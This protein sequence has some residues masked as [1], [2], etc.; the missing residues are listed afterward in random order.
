MEGILRDQK[1]L[2]P[3]KQQHQKHTYQNKRAGNDFGPSEAPPTDLERAER[4]LDFLSR[5]AEGDR[6]VLRVLRNIG[7]VNTTMPSVNERRIHAQEAL[8][9]WQFAQKQSVT[10]IRQDPPTSVLKSVNEQW[11]E[12]L[13]DAERATGGV[14]FAAIG[15]DAFYRR[16]LWLDTLSDPVA[17]LRSKSQQQR[18][19]PQLP[20]AKGIQRKKGLVSG[21]TQDLRHG[22]ASSDKDGAGADDNGFLSHRR[23]S[24]TALRSDF[25]KFV[26]NST[27]TI[28]VYPITDA[29]L[30][31]YIHRR[32]HRLGYQH[33]TFSKGKMEHISRAVGIE[34]NE[35][36]LPDDQKQKLKPKSI[37][38]EE[39]QVTLP[40]EK[41]S[42]R[43][44]RRTDPYFPRTII[45]RKKLQSETTSTETAELRT[46]TNK[47]GGTTAKHTHKGKWKRNVRRVEKDPEALCA[48]EHMVKRLQRGYYPI[49]IPLYSQALPDFSSTLDHQ[50]E[51][52]REHVSGEEGKPY[53][54]WNRQ[55]RGRVENQGHECDFGKEGVRTQEEARGKMHDGSRNG[56]TGNSCLPC[57]G[58]PRLSTR[59]GTENSVDV[60]RAHRELEDDV[61][62]DA[63]IRYDLHGLRRADLHDTRLAVTLFGLWPGG[64][65]LDRFRK[66]SEWRMLLRHVIPRGVVGGGPYQRTRGIGRKTGSKGGKVNKRHRPTRGGGGRR[67]GRGGGGA[68]WERIRD[69]TFLLRELESIK[70]LWSYLPEGWY[71]TTAR[72]PS[73]FFLHLS[74]P[75]HN[76]ERASK[77]HESLHWSSRIGIDDEVIV[78]GGRVEGDEEETKKDEDLAL[79]ARREREFLWRLEQRALL[80]GNMGEN[81]KEG[82]SERNRGNRG[83]VS[84]ML[85]GSTMENVE[86]K[87]TI[88]TNVSQ[89]EH[90]GWRW[91]RVVGEKGRSYGS[92]MRAQGYKIGMDGVPYPPAS[93]FSPWS[94]T[95]SSRRPFNSSYMWAGPRRARWRR[96]WINDLFLNSFR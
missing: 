52:V 33:E 45:V 40:A 93:L 11:M 25:D 7:T 30:R 94:Y 58:D 71:E 20:Q 66:Q 34:A 16:S 3:G 81:K 37:E 80:H 48:V 44:A 85:S 72:D 62:P 55:S 60:H 28:A 18:R 90:A 13:Q 29:K 86:R 43:V 56:S 73:P 69:G 67:G 5:A 65:M 42:S 70:D 38:Q 54:R 17:A 78:T 91:G 59:G 53:K 87:R 96:K 50:G 79:L 92:K 31:S 46:S 36:E 9:R 77:E 22:D 47:K 27:R 74:P 24:F 39:D 12:L 35:N 10:K 23:R 2:H 51:T 49:E 15:C 26:K 84:G 21:G 6:T 68:K 95:A 64:P 1:N 76:V 88:L 8:Q 61:R 32:C 14:P 19:K 41:K 83:R 57:N 82:D 89:K 63:H 75:V 4:S